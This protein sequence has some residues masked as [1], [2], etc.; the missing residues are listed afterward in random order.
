MFAYYIL[1]VFPFPVP[2]IDPIPTERFPEY[3]RDMLYGE[4]NKLK[5]EFLVRSPYM[6]LLP[7]V[8]KNMFVYTM[9]MCCM[10]VF[11]YTLCREGDDSH[12]LLCTQALGKLPQPPST[13]AVLPHNKAHNRFNNIYPCELRHIHHTPTLIPRL[14]LYAHNI[15]IL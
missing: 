12:I 15:N 14:F 9:Q 10:C 4:E 2:V 1:T 13:V 8:Y 3:V 6:V 7:F 11:P 5:A